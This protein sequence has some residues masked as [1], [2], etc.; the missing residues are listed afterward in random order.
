MKKLF[1]Y[2]LTIT[3][4]LI[5]STILAADLE[6]TC[7]P[8]ANKPSIN[9][10]NG[11]LFDIQNL[12]PGQTSVKTLKVVNTDTQNTCKISFKGEGSTNTLT[13][14]IYIAFSEIYGNIVDGKATSHKNISD[15]IT[16]PAVQIANLGPN[17][18][19]ERDLILTF[20]E[21][22][23]HEL[24]KSDTN[25]NIRI[26][27]EWGPETTPTQKQG[28]TLGE[29]TKTSTTKT[30]SKSVETLGTVGP[31]QGQEEEVKGVD[32]CEATNKLFGYVYVDRNKNNEREKREKILPNVSIKIYIKDEK[33]EKE[34]IKDL[35]T[36]EQGYWELKLC[37]GKY[38]IEVDRA[39]LPNS[40]DIQ[41]NILEAVLAQST[42]E[43]KLDIGVEDT[44]NF[45]EI[46]W[47]WILLAILFLLSALYLILKRRRVFK[48]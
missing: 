40:T 47:P 18:T 37:Q 25:F 1:K 44:R 8:T 29:S 24:S 26:I 27:S 20:N 43:Y 41:D 10:T 35:I 48:K 46:Y 42:T 34:T 11:T 31:T 13:N 30:I 33:G 36:D 12:M 38:F 4:L 9:I 5:P 16:Q 3:L 23:G 28:E 7:H 45:W 19:I 2:L 6:I 22:S 21:N 15:F 32:E 39:T 17:Q 14:N